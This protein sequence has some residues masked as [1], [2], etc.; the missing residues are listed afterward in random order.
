MKSQLFT[1]SNH[2]FTLIE[3]LVVI[4]MIGILSA[5]AVPSWLTFMNV[6]RLSAA[7]DQV[8][9]AMREAQSNAKRDK[10]TWQAS[11]R[12]IT[13]NGT[14]VVQWAVHVANVDPILPPPPI[15]SPPP[16]PR[17]SWQKLEPSIR[18]D[19]ETNSL[20]TTLPRSGTV[21]R[22]LF[23]Y[24][25]CPV[26]EVGHQCTQT[27]ITVQGRI[28][29]SSRNGGTAKRCVIISTLLGALRT[30]KEQPTPNPGD[31]RYCY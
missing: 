11:F 30:A 25:G 24:Q 7:Q 21:R 18:L 3:M 26:S 29:L 6:R 10:I 19:S 23:N 2:G 8:Y 1:R 9:L 12:E 16:N 27:S 20:E 17:G 13:E 22:V 4:L 31:G 14:P 15:P 28:T 5:I